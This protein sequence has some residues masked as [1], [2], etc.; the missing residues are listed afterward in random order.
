MSLARHRQTYDIYTDLGLFSICGILSIC[1]QG[2]CRKRKWLAPLNRSCLFC[3]N[4]KHLQFCK[5]C[6]PEQPGIL[7]VGP[8]TQL[9]TFLLE[10]L[11]SPR[12]FFPTQSQ[13]ACLS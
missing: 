13:P 1:H 7:P 5:W 4:R 3:I 8:K 10:A 6:E 9:A 12:E 11:N 2:Q